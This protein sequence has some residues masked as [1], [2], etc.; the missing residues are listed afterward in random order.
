[1]KV[2]LPQAVPTQFAIQ[3]IDALFDRPIFST[4]DFIRRTGISKRTALRILGALEESGR[5][6]SVRATRGSK[7]AVLGFSALMAITE[8]E[9]VV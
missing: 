6:S 3:A 9:S 2:E 7:P 5:L 4:T 1:M 8:G